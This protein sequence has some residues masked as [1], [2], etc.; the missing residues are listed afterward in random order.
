MTIKPPSC[1]T[2]KKKPAV[3]FRKMDGR[4]LCGTCFNKWIITTVKK[5]I[6]QKNM[7]ERNDRIIVG[8]SGGKDSTVLLDVL[9]KI[10]GKYPTEIIAVCIDEGINGYRDDGLPIAEMNAKRLDIEFH[11]FSFKDLFGYSLDEIVS[12][13]RTL[14]NDLPPT[15][16]NKLIQHGACSYCGV[17][18]R[19]ALNLAARKL[20]S[21]KVATGHNLNDVSQTILL[22]LLRGDSVKLLRGDIEPVKS[23]ELFVPRVK[24]LQMIAERDIVLYNVFNEITYHTTECP[25][26][27]EAMRLDVRNFLI[28]IEE[29]YPGTINSIR[30]SMEKISQQFKDG[31]QIDE[32]D[33]EKNDEIKLCKKCKEPSSS[34]I[35]K[36]C[37]MLEI[38]YEKN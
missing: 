18:R 1:Y 30:N 12:R 7:F 26:A 32:V 38:L 9:A 13:S 4:H 8:L 35:C 33:K 34:A 16:A 3:T 37:Q 17:F 36:G 15:R 5:T 31:F 25:Y 20:E 28:D 2:C 29:K 22:N 11:M 6:K 19:K 27:V 24:P 23:H 21:D 14:Q 10:E